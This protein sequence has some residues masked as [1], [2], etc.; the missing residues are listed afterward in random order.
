[1]PN[2]MTR[3]GF[4]PRE[5]TTVAIL[6]RRG[7]TRVTKHRY[8]HRSGVELIRDINRREWMIKG[9]RQDGLRFTGLGVAARSVEVHL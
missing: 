3:T 9:G 8:Q 2:P 7:W 4:A 6:R 1:M 5:K